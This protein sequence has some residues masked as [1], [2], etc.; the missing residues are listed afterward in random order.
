MKLSRMALLLMTTVFIACTPI[1][2]DTRNSIVGVW[3]IIAID[4]DDEP[5]TNKEPLPSQIIFTRRHY[6][7]V[8]MF[9]ED[10]IRAFAVR[11]HPTDEE[12]LKRFGEVGVNTG[13]Y[14]VHDDVIRVYPRIARMAEFMGGHMTYAYQWSGKSLIL[15]LIDEYTYDGVQA[16]WM[17]ES[18]GRIHLTLAR[19]ED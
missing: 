6:T 19:L 1:K 16:P 15:T 12:K 9:G 8:R 14:E 7:I 10:P 5:T 13:T 11:W 18:R 3:N 17:S 2:K 4:N